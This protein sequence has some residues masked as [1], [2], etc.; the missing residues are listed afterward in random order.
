[1]K[2]VATMKQGYF[3]D[4]INIFEC[5]TQA[6]Q[7]KTA[8]QKI[9]SRKLTLF[10]KS[11]FYIFILLQPCFALLIEGGFDQNSISNR[12]FILT[13]DILKKILK[14]K[15]TSGIRVL[16]PCFIDAQSNMPTV[17]ELVSDRSKTE[18]MYVDPNSACPTVLRL[19]FLKFY[20]V[21]EKR[22]T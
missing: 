7:L 20:L 14:Q 6:E 13:F 18:H 4:S 15:G 22:N 11:Y 10:Q 16:Y 2:R 3:E 5:I 9:Q 21:K 12:I 8:H 17:T 19:V 1:M